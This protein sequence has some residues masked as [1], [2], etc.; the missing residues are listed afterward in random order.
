MTFE[1]RLEGTQLPNTAKMLL[2]Q[3]LSSNTKQE[4][5][6]RTDF[7]ELLTAV[8]EC[9]EHGSVLSIEVLVRRALK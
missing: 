4:L 3:I 9:I 8:I 7:E 6:Q 5:L 2:P 1:E